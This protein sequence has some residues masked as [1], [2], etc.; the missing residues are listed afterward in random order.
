MSFQF[1]CP[2]TTLQNGKAERKI[3]TINNFICTLLA[4]ASLPPS[5]FHHAL[6][7]STYLLNILPTKQLTLQ[8][9]T[10]ILHQ[11]CPSFFHVK[12]FGCMYF[13]LIPSTT[14]NKLQSRSTPCVFLG[15]V[16]YLCVI[17]TFAKT[18]IHVW[19]WIRCSNILARFSVPCLSGLV[20]VSFIFL[21]KPRLIS[22][23][24]RRVLFVQNQ[25]FYYFLKLCQQFRKLWMCLVCS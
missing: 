22:C 25:L 21:R 15:Y 19:C 13:L 24:P 12:V 20:F 9:Q 14:R 10:A 23:W 16:G 17:F 3:R 5:V 11:Q 18:N 7:M 8:T 2:H 6:H 1:S 4:H